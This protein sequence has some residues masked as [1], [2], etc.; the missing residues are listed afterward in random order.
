MNMCAGWLGYFVVIIFSVLWMAISSTPK[1]IYNPGSLFYICIT[2][3]V[4]LYIPYATF[5]FFQCPSSTCLGGTN[6]ALV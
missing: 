2:A 6:D 4:G 5:S 1:L 3:F